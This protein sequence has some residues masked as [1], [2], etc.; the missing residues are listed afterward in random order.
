MCASGLRPAG[1]AGPSRKARE[2]APG[3]PDLRGLEPPAAFPRARRLGGDRASGASPTSPP[4]SCQRGARARP[5]SSEPAPGVATGRPPPAGPD[6]SRGAVRA[7]RQANVP[8]VPTARDRGAAAAQRAAYWRPPTG[9]RSRSSV[10]RGRPRRCRR[11]ASRSP[12][13]RGPAARAAG[14][15]RRSARDGDRRGRASAAGGRRGRSA[16]RGP[17]ARGRGVDRRA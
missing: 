4:T 5:P 3:S 2:R 9:R 17:P 15:A 12:G 6:P 8:H 10:M 7:E 16:R 1:A 13:A 11:P 14:R